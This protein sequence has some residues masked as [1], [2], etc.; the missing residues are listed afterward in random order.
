[1]I[2]F[3]YKFIYL[4]R[5]FINFKNRADGPKLAAGPGRTA[6]PNGPA[7]NLGRPGPTGPFANTIIYCNHLKNC[8]CLNRL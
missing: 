1:M 4:T 5:F 6:W 3:V 2:F 8:D 7:E